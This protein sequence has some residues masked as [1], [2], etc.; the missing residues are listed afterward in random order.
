MSIFISFEGPE[1]SGKTTQCRQ[2][3]DHLSALGNSVLNTRE[4]GG[5]VIGQKIRTLLLD[6]GNTDMNPV[7]EFLLF[8]A[9]R[10]QLVR[11]SVRPHLE[12]GGIVVCDR[13]F[14]SSLAY[15]GHGHGLDLQTLREITQ[16]A[17][18]GLTPDLTFLL[19][20]DPEAG[21]RRRNLNSMQLNRLDA[22]ELGFHRRAREG[23]RELARSDIERWVIVDAERSA[24]EIQ[25]DV[26]HH[27]MRALAGDEFVGTHQLG[28]RGDKD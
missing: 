9:S 4:P 14:D 15:Q 12:Q 26:R 7:T 20:L 1:G 18:E 8:S 23:F 6:G 27:V 25:A 22:Y 10:A 24:D 5:T 11:E 28:S 16:L 13:F 21:L 17:T 19:D 2:L 3:T